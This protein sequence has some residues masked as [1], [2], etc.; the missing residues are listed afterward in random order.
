MEHHNARKLP[1]EAIADLP[2][3]KN[4]GINGSGNQ[5]HIKTQ[6]T[7]PLT[8]FLAPLT[9]GGKTW[10][11][12]NTRQNNIID[13]GLSLGNLIKYSLICFLTLMFLTVNIIIKPGTVTRPS[14]LCKDEHAFT[15]ALQ[16]IQQCLP[17]NS[18]M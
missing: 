8:K 13:A 11:C 3:C 12:G 1:N 15:K 10:I 2:R 18:G 14:L 16:W 4:N 17:M 9:P 7:Q 5:V 6:F